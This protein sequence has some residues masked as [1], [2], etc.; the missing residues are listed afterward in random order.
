MLEATKSLPSV[1]STAIPSKKLLAR[2]VPL[3]GEGA[4]TGRWSRRADLRVPRR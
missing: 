4:V 2:T 3:P 1:G